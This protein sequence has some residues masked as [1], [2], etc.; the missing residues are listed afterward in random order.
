MLS[1]LAIFLIPHWIGRHGKNYSEKILR[2]AS[3]FN[4]QKFAWICHFGTI[5]VIHF[6]E[7][8]ICLVI[9]GAQKES[10]IRC[11]VLMKSPVEFRSVEMQRLKRA[12]AFRNP[13]SR[14]QIRFRQRSASQQ[15]FLR[16]GKNECKTFLVGFRT[17]VLNKL[18]EMWEK[19]TALLGTRGPWNYPR[20][21]ELVC[22]NK[23][24]NYT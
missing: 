16:A 21:Q 3:L 8:I 24:A 14:S 19:K 12:D 7:T 20:R 18:I 1:L 6:F 15:S 13:H 17:V 11:P 10:I 9:L 2:S 4:P 5:L 23:Q 22:P